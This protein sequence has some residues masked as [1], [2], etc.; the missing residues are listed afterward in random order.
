MDLREG[1]VGAISE[2][3][4]RRTAAA[5][6]EVSAARAVTWAA[7]QRDHGKPAAKP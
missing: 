4:S 3:M 2:G 1:V 6:F 5:R 7:F